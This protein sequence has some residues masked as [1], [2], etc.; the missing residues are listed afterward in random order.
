MTER[1]G[2]Y[3]A[4]KTKHAE[5]WRYLR[6]VV[7]YPINSTWIDEAGEGESSDLSDLW[8][9]CIREASTASAFV[10]YRETDDVLKGGWIE[11]GAALHAEV[12]VYAVGL[13]GFTVANHPAIRHFPTMKD[14]MTAVKNDGH[15]LDIRPSPSPEGTND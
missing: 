12:P 11:L 1:A 13:E 10:I 7:G 4:S 3:I 6:N 15:A 14:A 9:R 8:L 2:I 5:R